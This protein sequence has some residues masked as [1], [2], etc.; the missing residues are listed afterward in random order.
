MLCESR[1]LERQHSVVALGRYALRRKALGAAAPVRV[2]CDGETQT[3]R[4]MYVFE[5]ILNGRALGHQCPFG[6]RCD[7]RHP[8]DAHALCARRLERRV[9]GANK[10]SGDRVCAGRDGAAKELMSKEEKELHGG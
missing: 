7:S 3:T 2:K 6:N 8:S 9:E 10:R 5:L 4:N 1:C